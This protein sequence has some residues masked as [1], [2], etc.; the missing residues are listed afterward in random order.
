MELVNN[1]PGGSG[2]YPLGSIFVHQ[3]SQSLTTYYG[4]SLTLLTAS[5]LPTLNL[6]QFSFDNLPIS[7]SSSPSIYPQG[8]TQFD[9]A[10]QDSKLS[11]GFT[12]TVDSVP[13]AHM[14]PEPG[15]LTLFL[16]GAAGLA[17]RGIRRRLHAACIRRPLLTH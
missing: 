6:A 10:Y 14:V 1:S 4:A 2:I 13:G 16:L 17:A 12:A 11:L 3:G 7:R 9:Y 5:S 8:T 15:S